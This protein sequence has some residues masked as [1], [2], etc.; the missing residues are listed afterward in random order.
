[1]KKDGFR[2]IIF[3]VLFS[4]LFSFVS[5]QNFTISGKINDK[6]NGEAM[7]GATI[8]IKELNKAIATNA[9]G[10]YSITIPKGTYTVLFSFTGMATT[11]Q[12]IVLDKDQNINVALSPQDIVMDEVIVTGEQTDKNVQGTQMGTVSMDIEQIKAL[13]QFMGEVDVLKAIQLIPGVKSAGDGQTGFYVRGGGPDQNLVLLDEAVVYNASHLMGFFSVFNGDAIKNVTL[14][15]GGMPAQYGNR[16]SSVLDIQMKEG[17]NQRFQVEGGLGLISSRL[18][19]QGPIKKD[20]SSFIISARRTYVDV[21]IKPIF[22]K[23]SAFYGTSYYFYDLN[24]K[25]NYLFND[26]NKIYFSG[27]FGRDVFHF[28]DQTIGFNVDVPWGN[29][30]A[31]FRWNHIFNKKLFSNTSVIFSHYD[32]SFGAEE[33]G[34]EF[35]LFS[36]IRDWNAK[37]DFSWFPNTSHDVKWGIN[38]TFHTFIPTNVSAKQGETNFDF[39]HIVRL[40]AHDAQAYVS[41]D[42]TIT[43]YLRLNAGVRFSYFAQVGPFTRF[44]KNEFG[45][46]TDTINHR[47]GKKIV[48]YNGLEPRAAL[49]WRLTHSSSIKASF[50][51]N[52][53]YIHLASL[54]AVSLPTDVW[55][56]CTEIIKPQIGNQYAIGYFRNFKSDMYETSVEAYYKDMK[57][58]IEYKDGSQPQDNV[59]DNPDNSFTFGTGKAYGVE[60]FVKKR[61][62][63][64][65]GWI[66]YTL[67]WTKRKF[68]EINY[69]LEFYAKYDRRHDASV[70]LT[71]ELDKKWTF[72]AIW[73][74]GTGNAGTLPNSL[75]YYEGDIMTLYGLRNSYRFK[76]Y[77]RMDLSATYTP[78][79]N[80]QIQ[81]KRDRLAKRY[82]RKGKDVSQITVPKKWAKNYQSSWSFSIFNVYNRQNPYFI[83]FDS[84]GDFTQGTFKVSAKQV[85]LF[86]VLPSATWNFKF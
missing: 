44:V 62:G 33:D 9:Y 19:V 16:L 32:F 36:G 21:I 41:D 28:Q 70:V 26:K 25:F 27:Y 40:Y 50:T 84:T 11:T 64:F 75:A 78:S 57:N 17:N 58:L 3:S 56:P 12:T 85:S 83:Y 46:I 20:T 63:K 69:G 6:S 18:T 5:A 73:V 53:Q 7:I 24:T 86:P 72:S 10:F 43:D 71:Y 76:P 45:K 60:L 52:Y 51:R 2:K 81:R 15:K 35:K 79:R 66:G 82:E 48:D 23:G 55:M 13:P 59:Y 67:S 61:S 54:S 37:M 34:F 74:Y 1:V 29:T 22:R 4:S 68:A 31:S 8:F 80:R 14:T 42:W 47:N 39:G 38:Y 77:H 30:T 65:T 49:R